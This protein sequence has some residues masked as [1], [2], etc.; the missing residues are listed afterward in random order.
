MA[1]SKLFGAILGTLALGSASVAFAQDAPKTDAPAK[2]KGKKGKKAKD[3][4][5][6]DAKSCSGAD[7]KGCSGKAK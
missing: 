7:G 5:G 2:A 6:G 3:A 4:K 1:N